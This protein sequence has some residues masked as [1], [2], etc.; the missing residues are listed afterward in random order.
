M[1]AMTTDTSGAVLPSPADE[2]RFW[3]LLEAAWA[4]LGD[5][6]AAVRQR[7]IQR[8][9]GAYPEWLYDLDPWMD[10]FLERLRGLSDGLGSGELT[11]LDRVLERKLY[12]L[13]R[14]DVYDATPATEE[15]FLHARGYIVAAG[16]EFY[17][18]VQAEPRLAIED[19]WCEGM[20]WFFAHLHRERF[21][22]DPETGSGI[23]RE[24]YSNEAGWQ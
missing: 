9:P 2:A 4:E 11:G 12:D 21:G 14:R 18:A 5:E 10:P 1:P 15:G 22:G 19:A 24:S 8:A 23:S 13:D 20:G 7:L 3:A 6:P 17:Q 16:Q